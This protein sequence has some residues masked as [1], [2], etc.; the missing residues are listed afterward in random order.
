MSISVNDTIFNIIYGMPIPE[1]SLNEV[2]SNTIFN[3]NN[4][5]YI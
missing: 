1:I 5:E 2:S 3:N 4:F